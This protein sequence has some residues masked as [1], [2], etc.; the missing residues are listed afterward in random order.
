MIAAAKGLK[1]RDVKVARTVDQGVAILTVEGT[2][3]NTGDEDSRLDDRLPHADSGPDEPIDHRSRD[4]RFGSMPHVH[5]VGRACPEGSHVTGPE[6][7]FV[8]PFP[9][10][11][12]RRVTPE[13]PSVFAGIGMTLIQVSKTARRSN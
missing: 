3:A 11:V 1:L 7:R 10:C 6:D 2:I 5:W 9:R 13:E 8:Q 12:G 4:D